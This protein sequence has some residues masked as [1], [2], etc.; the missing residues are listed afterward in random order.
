MRAVDGSAASLP[1]EALALDDIEVMRAAFDAFEQRPPESGWHPSWS[2]PREYVPD[3]RSNRRLARALVIVRNTDP[4]SVAGFCAA[5]AVIVGLLVLSAAGVPGFPLIGV[6]CVAACGGLGLLVGVIRDVRRRRRWVSR[7]R[8]VGSPRSVRIGPTL[9]W[10]QTASEV[11]VLPYAAFKGV[12]AS[13]GFTFLRLRG[14]GGYLV[15][16][17]GMFPPGASAWIARAIRE[18]LGG[19]AAY[20]FDVPRPTTATDAR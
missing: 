3:A 19:P 5:V 1:P 18:R 14:R 4:R 17:S 2:A 6:L 12:R 10:M 9:I 11:L 20:R 7:T 16:P 15:L 8:P 13:S